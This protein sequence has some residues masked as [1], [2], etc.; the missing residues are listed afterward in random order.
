[1]KNNSKIRPLARLSLLTS[2]LFS[3]N[4]HAA[5][6][7]L[8]I[9]EI[10]A[11]PLAVGDSAG[12]WF[13]LYNPTTE[14]VDLNGLILSDDGS[15]NHVIS[16]SGS[17]FINPGEYF[18]LT[19]NADSSTNGGFIADYEYS[20]F[21][22][23]NTDDEIIFSDSMGELLRLNYLDGFDAP[24]RSRELLGLDMI[25]SN[26]SLTDTSLIYGMGDIGTPGSAG[27]FTP[28]PVPLP[29]AVWLF[30]TGLAGLIGIARR[31]KTR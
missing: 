13:E 15:N 26:Y 18:V 24:G 10:M 25:E 21:S 16:S 19:N 22:L 20:S 1:M 12:E 11:N 30:S 31:R 3:I 6:S 8:L 17:L 14:A 7:D 5:V 23:G 9:T 2:L 29:A 27:S 28:A 4:S